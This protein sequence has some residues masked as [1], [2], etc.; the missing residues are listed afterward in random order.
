MR[1]ILSKKEFSYLLLTLQF[2]VNYSCMC[3]W[4]KKGLFR[5]GVVMYEVF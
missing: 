1:H 5:A 3:D 4:G 2:M